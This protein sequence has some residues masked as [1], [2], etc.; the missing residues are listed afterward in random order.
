MNQNKIKNNKKKKKVGC[1]ENIEN[2]L[3]Q[4]KFKKITKYRGIYTCNSFLKYTHFFST[5]F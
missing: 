3:K 5:Y 4:T 1:N 2:K